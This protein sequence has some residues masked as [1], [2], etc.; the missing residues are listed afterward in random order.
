[1]GLVVVVEVVVLMRETWSLGGL[2]QQLFESVG[3]VVMR[4]NKLCVA[5][6][7]EINW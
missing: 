1:M 4:N 5:A 6:H 2:L 3:T 7:Y